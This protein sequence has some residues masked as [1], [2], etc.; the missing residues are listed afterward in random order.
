[1]QAQTYYPTDP[2][3]RAVLEVQKRH[4]RNLIEQSPRDKI[5]VLEGTCIQVDVRVTRGQTV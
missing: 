5:D 3:C 4:M 1:M 2:Q